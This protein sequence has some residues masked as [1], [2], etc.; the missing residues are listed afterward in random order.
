MLLY[1]HG[2]FM[3]REQIQKIKITMELKETSYSLSRVIWSAL[4]TIFHFLFKPNLENVT[5]KISRSEAIIATWSANRT[6][7]FSS[8][9]SFERKI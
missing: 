9:H 2:D 5:L 7:Y 3:P 8:L 1:Q 6:L 4:N